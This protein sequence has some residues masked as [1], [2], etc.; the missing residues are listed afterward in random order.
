MQHFMVELTYTV[1]FEQVQPVLADHRAHLQTGY[2][3]GMLLYSGGQVPRTGGIAIARAESR[4][5]LEAFFAR[6]PYR[7]AGVAEHRIVEFNPVN[8]QPFMAD[9]IAGT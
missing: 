6:D 8:M 1:P 9:W 5:A 4:A 3:S 7:L 2:D